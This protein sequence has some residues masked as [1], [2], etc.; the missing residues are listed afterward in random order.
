MTTPTE[1]AS[2]TVAVPPGERAWAGLSVGPHTGA[3]V[4]V[5]VAALIAVFGPGGLMNV[6]ITATIY[7]IAAQGLSVLAGPVKVVSLGASAFVGIGA[8]V[9]AYLVVASGLDLVVA[10]VL[11]MAACGLIGLVIAPIASKVSGIQIAVIT[12]GLA[13]LAQHIFRIA[14]PWTGGLNGIELLNVSVAGIDLNSAVAIGSVSIPSDTF[15]FLLCVL[16][17]I[18]SSVATTNL[19][20]S[21]TGRAMRM[22]GTSPL[23]ARSFGINP[24]RQR[25]VAFVYAAVL[26][27]LCGG[28]LAVRQ[29]HV[30]W[31]QFGM[32][33]SINLIAVVVLGGVGSVYGAVAGSAVVYALPEL[34]KAIAGGLPFVATGGQTTGVTP[35]QLTAVIYGLLLVLVMILEPGGMAAI[36]ARNVARLRSVSEV[37]K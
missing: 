8:F 12:V 30:S 10:L 33:M 31:D 18:I 22:T 17:L 26:G 27:G 11:A 35:D 15:F 20:R 23:G 1:A 21:R 6:A 9:A 24:G 3:L 37:R 28:L 25:A 34:I 5:V 29:S 14:T 7:A 16:I 36:A 19:L 32:E 13:Y 4:L 2:R